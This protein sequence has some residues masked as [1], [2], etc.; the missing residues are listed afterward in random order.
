MKFLV[1]LNISLILIEK[2]EII[3]INERLGEYET[4]MIV[5]LFKHGARTPSKIRPDFLKYF[6]DLDKGKLTTSGF[7]QMVYLGKVLRKK[8]F[9]NSNNLP[10][11]KSFFNFNKTSEQFLIISSPSPRSIESGIGYSLGLLP[12]E[13]YKI[14]D[15]NNKIQDE[16]P[17]PPILKD[18]P[19]ELK[20]IMRDDK[21]Y[22]F[23]IEN[24]QR[25][26]IFHS[27]R[28]KFPEHIYKPEIQDK[29]YNY[30]TG[31]ER[32]KVYE[33]YSKHFEISMRELII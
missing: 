30:L 27:R 12:E 17:I 24:R 32:V 23:I 11:Y 6:P 14:Y 15:T 22:N 25:N 10:G 4:V 29:N 5:N 19:E 9:E 20:N 16:N 1:Y 31:K 3:Y 18:K 26:F 13:T 21:A 28:C 8:Y 33:F 2:F 7:R